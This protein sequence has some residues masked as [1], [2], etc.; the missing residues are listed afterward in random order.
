MVNDFKV[1]SND[2]FVSVTNFK[3]DQHYA[4]YYLTVQKEIAKG[5]KV[6]SDIAS[7]DF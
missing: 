5:N 4:L 6:K 3:L 2:V 1:T 7:E